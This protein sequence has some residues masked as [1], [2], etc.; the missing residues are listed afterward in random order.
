MWGAGGLEGGVA[1]W[2]SVAGARWRLHWGA[3]ASAT[4]GTPGHLPAFRA[5]TLMYDAN[6]VIPA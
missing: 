4:V 1:R 6:A 5:A 3:L 2:L